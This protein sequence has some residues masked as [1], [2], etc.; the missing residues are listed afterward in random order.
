ME[1]ASTPRNRLTRSSAKQVNTPKN[2]EQDESIEKEA[3]EDVKQNVRKSRRKIT[4]NDSKRKTNGDTTNIENKISNDD[5]DDRGKLENL[6]L[7]DKSQESPKLTPKKTPSPSGSRRSL[8]PRRSSTSCSDLVDSGKKIKRSSSSSKLDLISTPTNKRG[9][10]AQSESKDFVFTPNATSENISHSLVRKIDKIDEVNEGEKLSDEERDNCN[11]NINVLTERD[12]KNSE[13]LEN[14]VS[15]QQSENENNFS[16]QQTA[17]KVSTVSKE[18]DSLTCPKT[19][20]SLDLIVNSPNCAKINKDENVDFSQPS[21]C[22]SNLNA[23]NTNLDVEIKT[24]IEVDNSKLSQEIPL[25]PT[26][27]EISQNTTVS[28]E[29]DESLVC[30]NARKEPNEST[31]ERETTNKDNN[32]LTESTDIDLPEVKSNKSDIEDVIIMKVSNGSTENILLNTDNISQNTTVSVEDDESSVCDNARKEPNETTCERETT[33]KDNNDLTKSIEIDL[34]EVKSNKSDIEDVIIMKVSNGSTENILL[35]TDND[36]TRESLNLNTTETNQIKYDDSGKKDEELKISK[37]VIKCD[38]NDGSP[39]KSNDEF[40]KLEVYDES[41]IEEQTNQQVKDSMEEHLKP[42]DD[43]EI[44]LDVDNNFG[45]Q[46]EIKCKSAVSDINL[47]ISSDSEDSITK[48]DTGNSIPI[49]S[50]ENNELYIEHDQMSIQDVNQKTFE[51]KVEQAEGEDD[52]NKLIFKEDSGIIACKQVENNSNCI[53]YYNLDNTT[54][55]SEA[56]FDICKP[57]DIECAITNRMEE[58]P[59]INLVDTKNETSNTQMEKSHTIDTDCSV[60][61]HSS[62]DTEL[63]DTECPSIIDS[64]S[65]Q[66]KVQDEWLNNNFQLDNQISD[67]TDPSLD[68]ELKPQDENNCDEKGDQINEEEDLD[69]SEEGSCDIYK[70]LSDSGS[71]SDENEEVC[72]LDE[73]ASSEINDETG[74]S[75]YVSSAEEEEESEE[76]KNEVLNDLGSE[77]VDIKSKGLILSRDG[78]KVNEK[79]PDSPMTYDKVLSIINKNRVKKIDDEEFFDM[80]TEELNRVS[81]QS[82]SDSDIAIVDEYL[83]EPEEPSNKNLQKSGNNQITKQIPKQMG[84][85]ISHQPTPPEHYTSGLNQSLQAH[86]GAA[87]NQQGHPMSTQQSHL[88]MQRT[89]TQGPMYQQFDHNMH[90]REHLMYNQYAHP[91]SSMQDPQMFNQSMG[92]PDVNYG[93]GIYNQ[94]QPLGPVSE[95]PYPPNSTSLKVR[96]IADMNTAQSLN[97]KN[98]NKSDQATADEHERNESIYF[99][100][101][102]ISVHDN[103]PSNS[104]TTKRQDGSNKVLKSRTPILDLLG[105]DEKALKLLKK[106]LGLNSIKRKLMKR[107]LE[108]QKKCL[109]RSI[110]KSKLRQRGR[111]SETRFRNLKRYRESDSSSSSQTSQSS[112]E[113]SVTSSEFSNT[114]TTNGSSSENDNRKINIEDGSVY[115]TLKNKNRPRHHNE[116]NIPYTK[117]I[118]YLGPDNSEKFKPARKMRKRHDSSTYE[119]YSKEMTKKQPSIVISKSGTFTV[120]PLTATSQSSDSEVYFDEKVQ[121]RLKKKMRN[122]LVSGRNKLSNLFAQCSSKTSKLSRKRV[123][124]SLQETKEPLTKHKLKEL[125]KLP[126]EILETLANEDKEKKR[127]RAEESDSDTT[128]ERPKKIRKR[129]RKM[130]VKSKVSDQNYIPFVTGGATEFG[131]SRLDK[132]GTLTLAEKAAK[133]RTDQLYGASVKRITILDLKHPRCRLRHE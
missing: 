91:S 32:D 94:P 46:S 56:V 17:A 44:S 96:T 115:V 132:D 19:E 45:K 86:H 130:K 83:M 75:E 112:Q 102:S 25:H 51:T 47:V 82:G 119:H 107:D 72:D 14:N 42:C 95:P 20:D 74:D 126:S 50:L 31:C 87:M 117:R 43:N 131:L 57:N 133:F 63:E 12:K 18:T 23:V 100:K 121:A 93:S 48:E 88:A 61:R 101:D 33:N 9:R 105:L 97:Y 124:E 54:A 69:K 59:V 6:S 89:F 80:F 27:I 30:G 122:D 106:V 64:A 78:E 58:M 109:E 37:P 41:V 73:S 70:G 71:Y 62:S 1:K 118:R 36:G 99:K 79:N 22:S 15:S 92:H 111:K 11:E 114:N 40:V 65:K 108:W 116:K 21:S 77:P 84:P 103:M 90:L 3:G 110:L 53:E 8:R 35:N 52:P 55:K 28:V 68:K 4:Q 29:D 10:R 60:P 16:N 26:V 120:D 38:D 2:V 98:Y 7:N 66:N 13:P 67:Q 76:V 128:S 39:N 85:V 125:K 24:N 34:P 127:Q 49:K 104:D 81:E 129:S 123:L 113:S 5:V